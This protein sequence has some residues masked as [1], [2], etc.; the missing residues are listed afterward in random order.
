[1]STLSLKHI[2]TPRNDRGFIA[3]RNIYLDKNGKVVEEN[4]PAQA[5]QL[6]G[7]GGAISTEM[8]EKYGLL[9]K[10]KPE[11]KDTAAKTGKSQEKK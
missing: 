4:D 5:I 6:I 10:A 8:A 2:G 9:E 1:M 7:K 11:E 3:D